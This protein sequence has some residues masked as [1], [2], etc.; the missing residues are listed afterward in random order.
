MRVLKNIVSQL[1]VYIVWLILS[2]VLWGFVFNI[3]TDAPAEKKLVLFAQTESIRDRELA[4]RL[5]EGKPEG[6]RLVQV[7]S[8]DYVM[9]D[10]SGLLNADFF[11]V[12]VGSVEDYR[13]AF[14]PLETEKLP[15]DTPALLELDGRP[16]GICVWDGERGCA[17]AYIGYGDGAYYLFL[18]A[19]SLHAG[20]QDDAAYGVIA[21]LLQLP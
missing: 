10:E 8:F 9:F 11:I 19:N 18:G 15:T 12:P 13:D 14:L 17:A 20:Q 16:C 7:H 21:E 2:V 5:E 1:H 3:L 4:V 6:I